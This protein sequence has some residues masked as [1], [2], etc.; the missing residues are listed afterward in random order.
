MCHSGLA[1]RTLHVPAAFGTLARPSL[2]AQRRPP[3]AALPPSPR[4]T[5]GSAG[6]AGWHL[7]P[8]WEGGGA[9]LRQLGPS[10]QRRAG[11]R[12]CGGCGAGTAAAPAGLGKRSRGE[13]RTRP[14]LDLCQAVGQQHAAG[15]HIKVR[16]VEHLGSGREG[17]RRGGS[18]LAVARRGML[19]APQPQLGAP[20]AGQPAA[21]CSG[22]TRDKAG[23]P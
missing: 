17:F 23:S 9:E 2:A 22:E 11:P 10:R 6:A 15:A 12:H 14:G 5:P 4:H 20:N 7:Q 16:D 13:R 8:G 3:A 21:S 1:E 19:Q 18:V